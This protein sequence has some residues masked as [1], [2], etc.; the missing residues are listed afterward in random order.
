V[1]IVAITNQ[2]HDK[3]NKLGLSDDPRYGYTIRDNWTQLSGY[4][5]SPLCLTPVYNFA[6]TGRYVSVDY[7][8]E[9]SGFRFML[10]SWLLF[11]G[12]LTFKRG[13]GCAD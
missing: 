10:V 2:I 6:K 13:K 7:T 1:N 4:H 11:G 9:P 12:K 8:F 3:L 5:G